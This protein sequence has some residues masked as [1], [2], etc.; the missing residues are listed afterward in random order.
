MIAGLHRPPSLIV[1]SVVLLYI[2]PS[3][4]VGADTT[5]GAPAL[6]YEQHVRPILKVACF[7]CHGEH[8][9]TPGGLDV[10]LVRLLVAGGDSGAAIVPGDV[11]G[12]LLWRRIAADE[13]P[14][15]ENKLTASQKE[16]IR[17]W[18]EQ[19][20]RTARP[21]PE[22]V[23]EAR[24][25]LEELEHW[26]FQPVSEPAVPQPAG[27]EL[28]T[29][30]DGFIARRLAAEGLPFSEAA[31]RR[32][33]IRRLTFDVIG[34]P[35]APQDVERFV[36][37]SA[38]DAYDRLVDRLL[39][40][41]QF[42]VRWGRHWLDVA[43]FA[44]SDPGSLSDPKR[45]H[46][47]RYRDYV[48]DAFNDNKP[49]DVFLREQLAGDELI[50]G[51]VDIYEA[52]HLELLTATGFLRMAA[53]PTQ[54]TNTVATRNTAA[55]EAVQ[56]IGSSL[57]GVTVGCAQCHDHKYDPIGIDDYYR[58]RAV[59][60]PVFPLANWKTPNAR[61]VDMTTAEV[62]AASALIE[63]EAKKL[64]EELNARRRA[65]GEEIQELRFAELPADLREFA[66]VAART[67]NSKLTDEQ[68]EFL[69]RN[70]RVRTI[71][72]ILSQLVEYDRAA[73]A[74]F[75][76][77]AEKIA[78]LRA[79]KPP[80]RVIM[81]TTEPTGEVP[82]SAIFFRGNP[83]SPGEAVL[84]AE[85]MVLRRSDRDVSVPAN[86]AS[87]KTTGRRLAYARQLTDGGHPLTARVF[88]NRLWLHH[89]GRG[90]VATPND[91]G[92]AG[93]APSHPELLDWLAQDFVRHGWD[94]KRIHRMLLLS[95]TYRQRSRRNADL[96]RLD[97]ENAWYGRARLRRLEAEAIRDAILSVTG[98]LSRKLGGPSIPVTKN[99][100]G[101]AILGVQIIKDGL[102]RGVDDQ[103]ADAF[104]RSAF[105][106][107][108][109]RLPLNM[110][111]TFDQPEMKPN[112]D[113]RRPTTVV[114]QALWFLNDSLIV[115]RAD[116]L[117]ELL[118]AT[119]PE[120]DAQL[121]ELFLR[122]FA[123]PPSAEEMDSSLSFLTTQSER[124]REH[125]DPEWQKTVQESPDAPK[126]RAMA[127][128]CQ[129]LLASN[130][131]LYVD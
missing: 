9:E 58:F 23:E 100:D 55:A 29:P 52:R 98:K 94:Q 76:K 123:E 48:V 19:G 116:D 130:R 103:H 64:D 46:A 93:E 59:F 115:E 66:R 20:A 35:P 22:C 104:R 27:Y 71:G 120:T 122:L 17:R 14:K 78:A 13:M 2:A 72:Q 30:I 127:S 91:F 99:G 110:L 38:P 74:E 119:S 24:F 32:T 92:I 111:A 124:F 96:D 34:L 8:D 113:V 15:G 106:E 33:L 63:A 118:F 11:Q 60:D 105:I 121:R 101:K 108:Q 62:Q 1:F 54:S 70:L 43:G 114:T 85:L 69:E 41:P 95:T 128:L 5:P 90:L 84:P 73:A 102:P 31:D 77:D 107:V 61:F 21:E 10:R 56:V 16:T 47:W 83:E 125:P 3:G 18:I 42:G 53:D 6:T 87:L 67:E 36:E 26:A 81:A 131:F 86:D 129:V 49:V 117:A 44:E 75:Q 28:R 50:D 80:S 79:T 65:R 68:K 89:M 82:A 40:S 37:D 88:V 4:S 51:D 112:C 126:M 45:P 39:A 12:S 97:P 109:R 57:L 7:H 25:T